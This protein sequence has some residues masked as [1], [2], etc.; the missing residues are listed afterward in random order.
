MRRNLAYSIQGSQGQIDKQFLSN[1]V[2]IKSHL[3]K[4]LTNQQLKRKPNFGYKDV[5]SVLL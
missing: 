3:I 2:V 4:I 1:G 5:G